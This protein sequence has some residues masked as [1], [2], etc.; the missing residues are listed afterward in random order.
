M[1]FRND[2]NLDTSQVSDQRGSSGLRRTGMIAGGGGAGLLVLVL[3]LLVNGL[4]RSGSNPLGDLADLAKPS[5]GGRVFR[6]ARPARTPTRM[7][8]AASSATSIAS[9][10]IGRRRSRQAAR[11]T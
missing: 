2:A 11:P 10:P 9:R 1:T 4:G 7:R 6:T 3:T 5:A 8:I